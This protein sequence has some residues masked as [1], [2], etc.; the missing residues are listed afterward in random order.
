MSSKGSKKSS[1][2]D[3]GEKRARAP[4]A[5]TGFILFSNE[6]RAE[7]REKL[8]GKDVKVTEISKELGKIWKTLTDKE[9]GKYSDMSKAL[10]EKL[11]RG[12]GPSESSKKSKAPAKKK[13]KAAKEDDGSDDKDDEDDE[14][15]EDE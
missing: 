2:K 15:E 1:K 11:S 7:V 3:K 9:K 14:E 13:K 5:P 8:G 12:E 10:Q 6:R 4:R